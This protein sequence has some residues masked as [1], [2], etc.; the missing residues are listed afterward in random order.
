MRSVN[1]ATLLLIIMN[2]FPQHSQKQRDHQIFSR[3]DFYRKTVP[4]RP[5][6]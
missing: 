3:H 1:M 6:H 2:E 4:V 5:I